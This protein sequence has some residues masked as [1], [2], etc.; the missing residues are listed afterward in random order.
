MNGLCAK[1]KKKML[2]A[3]G[4]KAFLAQNLHWNKR[5][6]RSSD[7]YGRASPSRPPRT[8]SPLRL[9]RATS[10]LGRNPFG[11]LREELRATGLRRATAILGARPPPGK[12]K[13]VVV[14][15]KALLGE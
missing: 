11:S 7:A 2:G 8:S 4:E 5:E 3:G 15:F 10:D 14:F 12:V 9:D 13:R 1:K 6:L